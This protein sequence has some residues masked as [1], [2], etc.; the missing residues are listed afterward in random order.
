MPDSSVAGAVLFTAQGLKHVSDEDILESYK[1]TI[2]HGVRHGHGVYS[3]VN[4]IKYR[5]AYVE[6]RKEGKRHPLYSHPGAQGHI[7]VPARDVRSS[8]G[9]N[10]HTHVQDRVGLSSL[11]AVVSKARFRGV[12]LRARG[13]VCGRTEPC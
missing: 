8:R 2:Q 12:N 7:S 9:V 1:G 11:M 10:T 6:G 3:W 4:G 13:H 5:G